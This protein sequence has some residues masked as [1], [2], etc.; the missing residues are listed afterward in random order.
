MNF[1]SPQLPNQ[2]SLTFKELPGRPLDEFVS[3]TQHYSF[4]SLGEEILS[5]KSQSS[6]S[7]K[8]SLKRDHKTEENSQGGGSKQRQEE[9]HRAFSKQ[10]AF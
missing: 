1:L 3:M 6:L 5:L 7:P 2:T 9:E 10:T 4:R 8:L